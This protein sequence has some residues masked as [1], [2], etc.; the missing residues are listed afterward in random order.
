[1]DTR[2]GRR[3]GYYRGRNGVDVK[4]PA[5]TPHI[6]VTWSCGCYAHLPLIDKGHPECIPS[7]SF[8]QKHKETVTVV[9]RTD[10]YSIRCVDCGMRPR[11]Y[12]AARMTALV[13]ATKHAVNKA[14]RVEVWEGGQKLETI[15]EASRQLM[16]GDDPPF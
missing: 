6:M 8:C 4:A 1:M 11:Y 12:G 15:G 10:S 16:L 5:V 2:K 7:E 3:Y 9:S 14:H 13:Y